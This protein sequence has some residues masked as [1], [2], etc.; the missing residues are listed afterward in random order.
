MLQA[1]SST[2]AIRKEPGG[3][4]HSA[5]KIMATRKSGPKA[6]RPQNS[7][8]TQ[9]SRQSVAARGTTVGGP[10]HPDAPANEQ[11]SHAAEQAELA[12]KMPYNAIKANEY[13]PASAGTPPQGPHYSM[14]SPS[15][16]ASTL[17]E[18]NESAKNGAA[19]LEAHA[20]DGSLGP[21]RV[22]SAD[23]VLTTNQGVP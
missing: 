22:N 2:Q 3:S 10:S 14:P 4:Q 21:K 9:R 6:R 1:V 20:L 7:R 8:K 17:S 5:R 11:A 13:A 23:Q 16:G 15:T 19:A 18:R 12:E